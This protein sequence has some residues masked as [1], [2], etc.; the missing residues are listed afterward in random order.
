MPTVA[1]ELC[2]I[3]VSTMPTARPKRG[4]LNI[5]II[6]PKPSISASGLTESLIS[7]M[8]NISTEKPMR[9]EPMSF[10]LLFLASIISSMPAS[11]SSGENAE[12][13]SSFMKKLSLSMPARLSIHAVR[14]VPIFEPIITPMV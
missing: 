6:S 3:P 4:L 9:Q 5:S 10:V 2:T 14:V 12:G 7:F 13:L 1:A 8:P 11:A